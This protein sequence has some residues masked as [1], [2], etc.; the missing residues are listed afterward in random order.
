MLSDT[1]AAIRHAVTTFL[2]LTGLQLKRKE[3]RHLIADLHVCKTA[4][5]SAVIPY[6]TTNAY[7]LE[8][9]CA[10]H[11]LRQCTSRDLEVVECCMLHSVGLTTLQMLQAPSLYFSSILR[12]CLYT[13]QGLNLGS[14]HLASAL[15]GY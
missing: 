5:C 10:P 4:Y 11:L 13:A 1:L 14:H 8:Q 6:V 9:T 15:I 7:C 2:W 12:A 3:K